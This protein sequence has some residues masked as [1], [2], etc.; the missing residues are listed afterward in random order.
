MK[1]CEYGP[2]YLNQHWK[3]ALKKK[4]N[5]AN[6][7]STK[8]IQFLVS[9]TFFFIHS[10]SLSLFG[11]LDRFVNY[12]FFHFTPKWSVGCSKKLVILLKDNSFL[13]FWK[14]FFSISHGKLDRL[15]NAQYFSC[16]TEM[17]CQMYKKSEEKSS[18]ELV[19]PFQ[20]FWN[21]F[22]LISY[23]KLARMLIHKFLTLL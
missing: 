17:V 12:K 14:K 21:K 23:G 19:N 2:S 3:F 16:Y 13:T 18:K 5:E 7:K 15:V 22:F 6:R 4:F 20:T 10:N 1:C 11:K 8:T 9:K